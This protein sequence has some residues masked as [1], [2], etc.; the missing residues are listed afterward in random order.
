[1][2]AFSSIRLS[3]RA[4]LAAVWITFMLLASLPLQVAEAQPRSETVGSAASSRC[5]GDGIYLYEHS[6]YG[7][8]CV[9]WT[10]DDKDFT[11]DGFNDTASSIRFVGS[12]GGGKYAVILFADAGKRG[13]Q[14][15]FGAD[16]PDLGNDKIGHDRA[17][18]IKIGKV[19]QCT[20]DGVY[21]YEDK[22][23]GG[24]C[25]KFV[26]SYDD[27]G[28]TGFEDIASS[29]K[30]VGAYGGGRRTVTLCAHPGYN[31]AC[32]MLHQDDP[33]LGNN[34]VGH[35]RTSS[36]RIKFTFRWPVGKPDGA[37]F[38]VYG[39]TF[40]QQASNGQGQQVYNPGID[41]LRD[42]GKPASG[43]AVYAV[44]RGRVA[45]IVPGA[46]IVIEHTIDSR[47]VWT[48]YINVDRYKKLKVGQWVDK[49]QQIGTINRTYLRFVVA[50]EQH[51]SG[52]MVGQGCGWVQS[53]YENPFLWLGAAGGKTG[54]VSCP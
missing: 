41:I 48:Q 47:K 54:A 3:R 12:Y 29:I 39:A 10:A 16:D 52:D 30:L 13:V 25:R 37:G 28:N 11:D 19:P 51:A 36:L 21:L 50:Y 15:A 1:M 23:Y 2:N 22:N 4:G 44:D 8:R 7:G 27:M 5:Q 6:N 20:G 34:E 31:G 49:G 45:S 18:S 43:Q 9:K 42:P 46:S 32:T 35:D 24:R 53:H 14:A 26:A 33:N 17:S 38:G 40:L